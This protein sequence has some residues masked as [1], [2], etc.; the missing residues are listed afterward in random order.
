MRRKHPDVFQKAATQSLYPIPP[1]QERLP[2]MISGAEAKPEH[3]YVVWSRHEVTTQIA[4]YS[5]GWGGWRGQDDEI[6]AAL[7]PHQEE[8]EE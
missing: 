4:D 1:A 3:I 8:S 7:F 6:L 5:P 2:E